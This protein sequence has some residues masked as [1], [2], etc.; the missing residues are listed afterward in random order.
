MAKRKTDDRPR[1]EAALAELETIARELEDGTIGLEES[2][3][4]FE[5][6]VGLLRHCYGILDSAEKR[7][8]VLT[9]VDAEGNP[10]LEPF[11]D[12]ATAEQG[13]AGRRKSRAKPS[14]GDAEDAVP[15][16]G[17]F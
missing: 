11:D 6:G 15:D 1:F 13:T 2:L 5:Q 3:A 17:L 9:G 12:S 10:V 16:R 14:D 7:I 8:A 4:R